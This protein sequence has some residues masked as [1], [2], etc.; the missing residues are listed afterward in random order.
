VFIPFALFMFMFGGCDG[1]SV[2]FI[3]FLF[4]SSWRF[5]ISGVAG[6]DVWG[7]GFF[8]SISVSLWEL[9]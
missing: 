9:S 4:V 1:G 5:P 8:S 3:G 2:G 7:F 6:W